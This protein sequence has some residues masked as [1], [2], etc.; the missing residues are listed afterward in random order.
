MK[1][2]KEVMESESDAELISIVTIKKLDYQPE[3]VA[4]AANELKKRNL[5]KSEYEEFT[6]M[7]DQAS[8]NQPIKKKVLPKAK[9]QT[10]HNI[11][12][13]I[14]ILVCITLPFHYIPS[15]FEAFP[16]DTFTFSNTIISEQ[17]IEDLISRYNNA[18]IFEKLR[19]ADEPL[20]KKLSEKGI[21]VEE[22]K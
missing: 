10:L 8:G 9:D 2:L 14:L 17:D 18:S 12:I 22:K 16:K 13:S 3:A 19:I 6:L 11:G 20:F 5:W 21:I 15:R 4:E 1:T 7:N